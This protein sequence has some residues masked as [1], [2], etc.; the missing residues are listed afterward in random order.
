MPKKKKFPGGN[1]KRVESLN[2][3]NEEKEEEEEEEEDDKEEEEV[4]L[5]FCNTS[6]KRN[7]GESEKKLPDH[8]GR[9][10]NP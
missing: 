7:V 8:E 2:G 10:V 6:R 4:I 1:R 5:N 3:K 9:G